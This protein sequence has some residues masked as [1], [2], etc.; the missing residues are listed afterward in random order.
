MGETEEAGRCEIEMGNFLLLLWRTHFVSVACSSP[1]HLSS[2]VVSVGELTE[3]VL[4]SE[5]S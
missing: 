5:V 1:S 2:A 3:G 4:I